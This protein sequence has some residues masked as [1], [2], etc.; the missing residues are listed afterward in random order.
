MTIF[1]E[2]MLEDGI[3]VP[4]G[5]YL[6]DTRTGDKTVN[7][8]I[9]HSE[10]KDNKKTTNLLERKN[11]EQEIEIH[12][13]TIFALVNIY[14]VFKF[15]LCSCTENVETIAVSWSL[16]HGTEN[17]LIR[18]WITPILF[19]GCFRNY[20]VVCNIQMQLK[21]LKAHRQI[22]KKRCFEKY[23]SCDQACRFSAF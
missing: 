4:W 17:M 3:F 21:R 16:F 6:F 9:F 20:G 22:S 18:N 14:T 10:K 15:C 11:L 12:N 23:C 7:V 19:Y 8:T 13:E 2:K 5:F 1:G